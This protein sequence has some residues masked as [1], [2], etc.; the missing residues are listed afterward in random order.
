MP[1]TVLVDEEPTGWYVTRSSIWGGDVLAIGVYVMTTL[2]FFFHIGSVEWVT[3]QGPESH[4]R[5][6]GAIDGAGVVEGR[7]EGVRRVSGVVDAIVWRY[8]A[9]G[10]ICCADIGRLRWISWL[11]DGGGRLRRAVQLRVAETVTKGCFSQLK[12]YGIK[13]RKRE[14]QSVNR[15]QSCMYFRS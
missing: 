7:E 11:L 5:V 6:G 8:E 4:W 10:G 13:I 14:H 12:G 15:A 2:R 9:D 3:F 1:L